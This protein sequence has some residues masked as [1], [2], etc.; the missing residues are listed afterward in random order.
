MLTYHIT[1]PEGTTF[2]IFGFLRYLL[3]LRR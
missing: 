2:V 1:V 3:C